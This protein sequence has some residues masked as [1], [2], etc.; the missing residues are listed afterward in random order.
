[1]NPAEQVEVLSTLAYRVMNT[2]A[3]QLHME[4][5]MTKATTL[6]NK[7]VQRKKEKKQEMKEKG[8]VE[9]GGFVVKS[10]AVRIYQAHLQQAVV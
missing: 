3:V 10:Y 7:V 4:D 5:T 6:W 9:V 8:I 2:Y 1:M